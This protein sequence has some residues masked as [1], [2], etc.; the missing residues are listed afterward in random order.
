MPRHIVLALLLGIAYATGATA[1][2]V[3]LPPLVQPPGTEHHVGKI[4]WADLLTP[5]LDASKR[6]YGGLFGWSFTDAVSGQSGYTVA[7]VDG[8]PVAGFIPRATPASE[9]RQPVWLTFIAVSDVDA[10]RRTALDHGAKV[11]FEPKTY[12]QRGRQAVLSDPEGAAFAIL[13][14]SSGDPADVLAE[15][16]E[17]IWSSLQVGDP[18]RDAAFYQT[19][20]GYEVFDVPSE[21]GLKHMILSSD[22]FARASVNAFPDAS[23][24]RHPHWL[25]FVRVLDA[26]SVASK[27]VALGGR[28][29]VEP[30]LDRHGGNVAVIADPNGAPIGIMEWSQNDTTQEP[31]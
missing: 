3:L 9:R 24:G 5:D 6:F 20:F 13:A 15:P 30:R 14:S 2:S 22:D 16:G 12:P 1:A 7:Y 17:W 21:D 8:R 11:V 31:R 25:D 18:A 27:A 28:V 23:S 26:A 10:A 19:L 29:L 4:V